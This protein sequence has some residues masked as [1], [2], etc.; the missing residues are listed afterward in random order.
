MKVV[1]NKRE[2]VE[3]SHVD[4]GRLIKV[5]L[6]GTPTLCMVVSSSSVDY[7]AESVLDSNY[8]FY[9]LDKTPV[10]EVE[11]GTMHLLQD[12][13]LCEIVDDYNFTVEGFYKNP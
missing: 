4:M 3:V 7:I 12:D 2:T 8:N 11:N 1:Y 6:G 5:E 9:D 13:T 10:V